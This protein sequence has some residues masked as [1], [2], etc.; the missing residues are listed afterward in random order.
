MKI[1]S[2]GAC[3]ALALAL[4]IIGFSSPLPAA[5]DKTVPPSPDGAAAASTPPA[6]KGPAPAA[7]AGAGSTSLRISGA[8]FRPTSNTMGFEYFTSGSMY[9]TSTPLGWWTAPVYLPQGAVL[10]SVRMFYYDGNATYDCNANFGVYDFDIQST[11]YLT[12]WSSSGSAGLGYADSATINHTVDN[13]KYAYLLHW[14]PNVAATTM[15]LVGFQ[16]FYTPPP[17]RAAVI[18]LY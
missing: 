7:P 15:Q 16:L 6:L 1:L 2:R 18:P 9:A 12:W 3:L 8:A 11:F 5:Q 4:L 10:T 13:S 14:R 17:G